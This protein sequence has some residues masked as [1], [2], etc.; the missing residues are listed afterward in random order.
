MQFK[1]AS[2]VTGHSTII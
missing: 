1:I 2:T